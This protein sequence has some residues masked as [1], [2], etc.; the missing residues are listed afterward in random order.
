[1]YDKNASYTGGGIKRGIG[2]F[3]GLKNPKREHNIHKVYNR[4]H[5]YTWKESSYTGLN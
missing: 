4:I 2:N 1:M 5:K 3:S